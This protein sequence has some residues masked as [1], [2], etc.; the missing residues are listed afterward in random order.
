LFKAIRQALYPYIV[1][2]LW[3]P[4][5]L[6]GLHECSCASY[7]GREAIAEYYGTG[8]SEDRKMVEEIV[9]QTASIHGACTDGLDLMLLTL[10]DARKE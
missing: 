9:A 7:E 10:P 4:H 3:T 1:L 5:G 8:S 2:D 6:Q